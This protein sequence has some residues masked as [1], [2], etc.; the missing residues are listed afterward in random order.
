MLKADKI[1][2]ARDMRAGTNKSN[3]H[4]ARLYD[5]SLATVRKYRRLLHPQHKDK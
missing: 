5:C 1:D 4:L 2:L 3:E